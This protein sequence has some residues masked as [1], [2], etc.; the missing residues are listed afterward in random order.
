MNEPRREAKYLAELAE[1]IADCHKCG[2]SN[3]TTHVPGE[4][5]PN[6][7]VMFVGI[8]PSEEAGR[9]G[10]P[11]VGPTGKLLNEWLLYIALPR[12]EVYLTN[13]VKCVMP[14]YRNG[15]KQR[16]L[17]PHYAEVKA[18]RPFLNLEVEL[19]QPKLIVMLG[20]P[21]VR[22]FFPEETSISSFREKGT[23]RVKAGHAFFALSHPSYVM[24]WNIN[25]QRIRIELDEL[26]L[27]LGKLG[28]YS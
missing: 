1:K 15:L 14:R 4:G 7:D 28:V 16:P 11:F 9:T 10:K 23:C 17:V 13:I 8:A 25:E 27:I 3:L 6:A 2:I 18:C 26:V 22:W 12:E 19:V 21:P 5:L 24:Q 20:T